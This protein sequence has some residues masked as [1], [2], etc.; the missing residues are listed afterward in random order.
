MRFAVLLGIVAFGAG[1]LAY[2]VHMVS[3]WISALMGMFRR[4]PPAPPP[5]LNGRMPDLP[6][7]VAR[8]SA[9]RQRETADFVQSLEG[10][11]RDFRRGGSPDHEFEG[12]LMADIVDPVLRMVEVL[13]VEDPV[14]RPVTDA[15]AA[16]TARIEALRRERREG[17]IA[18]ASDEA[19]DI[20]SRLA[21]R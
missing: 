13:D 2:L 14:P 21:P 1:V 15:L 9:L 19:E 7:S 16:A 8:L 10:I 12:R 3:G 18:V 20:L 17:R 5:P 11:S 6:E 4:R